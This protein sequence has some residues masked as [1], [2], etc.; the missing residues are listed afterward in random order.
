MPR[1][2]DGMLFEVHPAPLKDRE[3]RNYVYVRPYGLRRRTLAE[4]DEY[5][6]RH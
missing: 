5:C 4:L 6:A 2:E 1:K 3:G